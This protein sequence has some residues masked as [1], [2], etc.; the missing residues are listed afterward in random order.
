[1]AYFNHAFQKANLVTEVYGAAALATGDLSAGQLGLVDA[2]TYLTAA[3]PA[4]DTDTIPTNF[5]LVEGNWN[6]DDTLGN[7]PGQGG[8]AESI[9]TKV[10]KQSY[11]RKLWKQD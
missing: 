8:Y 7:N 3:F 2:S 4:N 6:Q 9:K 10:I 5:L 11:I 1:M